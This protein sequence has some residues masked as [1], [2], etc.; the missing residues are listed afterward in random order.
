[1]TN[2]APAVAATPSAQP[3]PEVFTH[4]PSLDGLRAIAVLLVA[5][6]HGSDNLLER[7][8]RFNVGFIG[9]GIFFV[10]SG[11]LI[12]SLLLRE[13]ENRGQISLRD[14]YIRRALR[15]WPLYYT[16]LLIHLLVLVHVPSWGNAWVS[17]APPRYEALKHVWWSYVIFIQNYVS[18][19]RHVNLGL[20][21]YWSLAIEEQ[22]YFVWP[23][24]LI[25]LSRARWRWA[26]PAFLLG[27]TALSFLLRALTIQG[28]L[29]VGE[30]HR[31]RRTPTCSASRSGRCWP[32]TDGTACDAAPQP[33][34]AAASASQSPG[35]LSWHSSCDVSI[36]V[37]AAGWAIVLPHADY[38]EP[39]L[40]SIAVA[41]I[42]DY[43]AAGGS[44]WSPLQWKPMVYIGRVSTACTC[45][46]LLLW[47]FCSSRWR[48]LAG[49]GNL[50][51]GNCRCGRSVLRAV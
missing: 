6:S 21:V 3:K 24:V 11:Y 39:L 4:N 49:D 12:T 18:D 26:P 48:W 1:M 40:L 37:V 45:C 9:V 41:A 16:V 28:H 15:I 14:F 32:G 2:V 20:G 30:G 43:V 35:L 38:Y 47:V 33:A 36:P 31:P 10:L 25:V 46:I 13:L 29:S 19:M 51:V 27:A 8:G 5:V 17:T 7:H 44:K 22:Y 23:L 50:S 42:I 34:A